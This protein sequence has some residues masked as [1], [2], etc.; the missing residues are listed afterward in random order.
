MVRCCKRKMVKNEIEYEGHKLTCGGG[1][2]CWASEWSTTVRRAWQTCSGLKWQFEK[3]K[4]GIKRKSPCLPIWWQSLRQREQWWIWD[5]PRANTCEQKSQFRYKYWLSLTMPLS[6]LRF[7]H[8]NMVWL[9]WFLLRRF[10]YPVPTKVEDCVQNVR[11]R[12][13]GV[14]SLGGRTKMGRT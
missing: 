2:Y 9:W 1:G 8:P 12:S 10:F 11:Q 4:K 5:Q 14:W 13:R 7:T 6:L 3:K